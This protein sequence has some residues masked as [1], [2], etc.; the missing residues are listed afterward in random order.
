MIYVS[1]FLYTVY[2]IYLTGNVTHLQYTKYSEVGVYEE[3]VKA[4][5][6]WF[7]QARGHSQFK[8]PPVTLNG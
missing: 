1:V 3:L 2:V 6:L 7:S 8:V 5:S 4:A